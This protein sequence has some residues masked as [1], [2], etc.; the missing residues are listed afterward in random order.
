MDA[1][2]FILS[3]GII[4]MSAGYIFQLWMRHQRRLMIHRERLAAIEK[5]IELPPLEQEI[6]RSGWNVQR[7][8]LLAGLVWVSVGVGA[9][10]LL[11]RLGGQEFKMPWGYDQFGNPDWAIVPVPNGLEWTGVALVGIGLSHLIVYWVGRKRDQ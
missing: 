7:L 4:V 3:L 8:L 10:P 5:G 6:R 2:V 11:Q 1:T 9:F